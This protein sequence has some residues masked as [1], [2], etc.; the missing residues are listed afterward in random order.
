MPVSVFGENFYQYLLL[1]QDELDV[2]EACS[3]CGFVVKSDTYRAILGVK[4]YLDWFAAILTTYPENES[5][6]NCITV[7]I[8]ELSNHGVTVNVDTVAFLFVNC[9]L[10]YK[11][12]LLRCLARLLIQPDLPVFSQTILLIHEGVRMIQITSTNCMTVLTVLYNLL[13]ILG[14]FT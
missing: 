12:T 3:L 11:E 4:E 1:Q 9:Q 13:S 6:L 14:L 10:E 2:M 7:V 8:C 5:I